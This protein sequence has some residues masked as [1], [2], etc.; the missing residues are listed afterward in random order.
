MNVEVR[1]IALL[2]SHYPHVLECVY[3]LIYKYPNE[4]KCVYDYSISWSE[5]TYTNYKRPMKLFLQRL[6]IFLSYG[7]N[8]FQ[9]TKAWFMITVAN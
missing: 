8:V 2:L 5:T 1:N 3:V 4:L 9:K 7:S 6:V